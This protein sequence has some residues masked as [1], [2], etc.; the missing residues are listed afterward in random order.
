MFETV[1]GA[2]L[3]VKGYL[4]FW[5]TPPTHGAYRLYMFNPDLLRMSWTSASCR[6]TRPET[7]WFHLDLDLD[8]TVLKPGPR[9]NMK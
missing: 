2:G 4:A 1:G 9:Q 3:Q 5:R 7:Q 8:Q 6:D